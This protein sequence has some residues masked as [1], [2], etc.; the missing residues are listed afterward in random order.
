MN[1]TVP[2]RRWAQVVHAALQPSLVPASWKDQYHAHTLLT[3]ERIKVC[4]F[5]SRRQD[6]EEIVRILVWECPIRINEN[7]SLRRATGRNAMRNHNR[8]SLPSRLS[9][10]DRFDATRLFFLEAMRCG[11]VIHVQLRQKTPLKYAM[12]VATRSRQE[13]RIG[14]GRASQRPLIGLPE[15]VIPRYGRVLSSS[16]TVTV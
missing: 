4:S 2:R 7:G 9:W 10:I 3:Q 5:T 11:E 14:F 1:T 6:S 16:V 12:L 13:S 8:D 15:T